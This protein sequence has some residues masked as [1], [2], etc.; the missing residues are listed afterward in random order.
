MLSLTA[1]NLELTKNAKYS[2]LSANYN[3]GVSALVVKN[4]NCAVANDY[5]LLGEFGSQQS[6]IIKVSTVTSATHTLNLATATIFAHPQDTKVSVIRYN[7]VKYYRTTTATFSS[8]GTELTG[9]PIDVQANRIN[10][11]YQDSTNTTGY[12]WFVF[13]NSTTGKVTTNSNAI[14]YGGF[15]SSSVKEI[16]DAFF[17]ALNN[18]EQKLISNKDAFT[19]LNE[20]YAKAKNALNL[21][22]PEFNVGDEWTFTVTSSDRESSLNESPYQSQFGKI[23]CITDEDGKDVPYIGIEGLRKHD[24]DAS[25]TDVRYYLRGNNIGITPVPSASTTY[26]VYFKEKSSVLSSYYDSINLPN[27]N[28]YFLLDFMLYRAS[29]KLGRNPKEYLDAFDKSI[30]EMKVNSFKQNNNKDS[31]GIS[32]WANI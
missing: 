15:E 9:S 24:N 32:D 13:Y 14:P 5:V 12:G 29:P 17:S 28:Y 11:I 8:S 20:G 3:S 30:A 2:Y 27:N 7:Q 10:T 16:F 6:E 19:W 26:Y 25:A 1:S 22:N 21:V 18:K 23:K 31:W 4:S